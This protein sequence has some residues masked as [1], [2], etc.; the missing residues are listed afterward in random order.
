M[1]GTTNGN[2]RIRIKA[3]FMLHLLNQMEERRYYWIFKRSCYMNPELYMCIIV[4]G[5]DQNTT[6]VPRMRQT[7]KNIESWFVKTHLCGALVHVIGLYCNVW[8]GTHYKH[9]SNQV[10]STLL[11]VIGEV[12]HKRELCH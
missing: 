7:V 3:V 6:M 10:V 8:F 4:D 12:L 1:E 5:M 11:Y 2:A 9:N